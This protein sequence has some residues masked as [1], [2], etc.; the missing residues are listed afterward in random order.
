MG[1]RRSAYGDVGGSTTGVLAAYRAG[2]PIAPP[3]P[4]PGPSPRRPDLGTR[5]AHQVRPDAQFGGVR[6]ASI[7]ASLLELVMCRYA[8]H[9]LCPRGVRPFVVLLQCELSL[10]W[11]PLL[12][13]PGWARCAAARR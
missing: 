13:L 12:S 2:C 3:K 6:A 5:G 7:R 8:R 10:S 1:S 11:A 9:A 4:P